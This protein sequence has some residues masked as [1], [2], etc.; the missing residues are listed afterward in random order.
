MKKVDKKLYP[1]N[2]F[3]SREEPLFIKRTYSFEEIDCSFVIPNSHGNEIN[4]S[5]LLAIT[6]EEWPMRLT[7]KSDFGEPSVCDIFIDD[8]V[9][10][11]LTDAYLRLRDH[12]EDGETDDR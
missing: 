3:F 2:P 11:A 12:Y 1:Q 9:M 6:T 7:V 10:F 5:L 8:E 4:Q